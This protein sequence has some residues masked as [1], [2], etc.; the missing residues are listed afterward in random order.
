MSVSDLQLETAGNGPTSNG[1]ELGSKKAAVPR[2]DPV[3]RATG[4]RQATARRAGDRVEII[5][6]VSEPEG[7]ADKGK[8]Q[9]R[10]WFK[11]EVYPQ[12]LNVLERSQIHRPIE[13]VVRWKE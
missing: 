13:L 4:R 5:V 6:S 8:A 11:R 9:T 7:V 12:V 3:T 10:A 1:C 2:V